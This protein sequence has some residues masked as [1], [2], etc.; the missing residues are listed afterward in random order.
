MSAEIIC[1]Y[2]CT[3]VPFPCWQRE[4]LAFLLIT[5]CNEWEMT[6]VNTLK[7]Q[8]FVPKSLE[9][10]IEVG[11]VTHLTCDLVPGALF[12][13]PTFTPPPHFERPGS[14]TVCACKQVCIY[15]W[16]VE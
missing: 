7:V 2:I 13:Q 5:D 4:N 11:K 12:A 9:K 14:A 8:L 10:A 15:I 1:A 6:V 3:C 16:S